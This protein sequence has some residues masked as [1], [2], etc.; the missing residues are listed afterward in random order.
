MTSW[1]FKGF[2]NWLKYYKIL[3]S[4]IAKVKLTNKKLK[5]MFANLSCSAF[6]S[7]SVAIFLPKSLLS[8]YLNQSYLWI[9]EISDLLYNCFSFIFASS[10]LIII[11]YIYSQC[12]F[13][14]HILLF[15]NLSYLINIIWFLNM[16]TSINGI[17][18]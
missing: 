6:N 8:F 11:Y 4:S 7:S 3:W 16:A 9:R 18:F 12:I 17:N 14:H 15:W 10:T 5:S 2:V 13:L 1:L